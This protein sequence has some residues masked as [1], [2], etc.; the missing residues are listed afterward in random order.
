MLLYCSQLVVRD[1]KSPTTILAAVAEWLS[2]KTGSVL[3]GADLIDG[4]SRRG[5]DGSAIACTIC[6]APGESCFAIQYRH[7]DRSFPAREWITD[8]GGRLD[9]VAWRCSISL[10]TFE[11]SRYIPPVEQTTRPQVVRN[12]VERCRIDSST[13]GCSAQPLTISDAEAF[14]YQIKDPGRSYP[15]VVVSCDMS[16][17]FLVDPNRLA[18]LLT[19]IAEVVFVPKEVDTFHLEHL[20]TPAYSAYGGA[21][22]IIW[23]QDR[24]GAARIHTSKLIPERLLEMKSA[25]PDLE[26]ELLA[27]ICHRCNASNSRTAVTFDS[28][29]RMAAQTRLH[30]ALSKGEPDKELLALY[31]D[32]DKQQRAQIEAQKRDIDGLLDDLAKSEEERERL[33]AYAEALKQTIAAGRISERASDGSRPAIPA[34]RVLELLCGKLDLEKCL[35]VIELTFSD[36]VVILDSARRSAEESADFN[37]PQKALELMWKLCDGYWSAIVAGSDQDARAVFGNSYAAN[38]SETARNNKRA[39][40]LRCFEYK[41]KQVE[42]M[43]HLKIGVKE[44]TAETWRLHFHWDAE[45]AKIVIGHCGKHLDHG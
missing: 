37:N 27:K 23:H 42:M 4:F 43:K 40:D 12:I 8:I 3:A 1:S 22:S 28:V 14:E 5:N 13:I 2:R 18:S 33:E 7:P 32:A 21:V 15:L 31:E 11:T 6:D 45:D 30:L 39:R 26:S 19:G 38:E 41:G 34:P 29:R 44:S 24:P 20:L 9:G 16:G 10:A 35:E 17:K 36:R 25:N